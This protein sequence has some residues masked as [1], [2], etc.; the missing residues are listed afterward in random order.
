MLH[1]TVLCIMVICF[2][3]TLCYYIDTLQLCYILDVYHSMLY[4]SL[5]YWN[6]NTKHK[7]LFITSRI[8][9]IYIYYYICYISMCEVRLWLRRQVLDSLFWF[10]VAFI[11]SI[12]YVVYLYII[13]LL[14]I[15]NVIFS[16]LL[17]EVKYLILLMVLR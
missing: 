10:I 6:L 4:T 5:V 9:I 14:H 11:F 1:D 2:T 12:L 15:N 8:F 17:S 7:H 3:I 16:I 13:T